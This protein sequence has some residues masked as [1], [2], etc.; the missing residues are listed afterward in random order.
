MKVLM[1][2]A[3]ILQALNYDDNL[4]RPRGRPGE[5]MYGRR[6]NTTDNNS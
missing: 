3:L 4:L 2:L 5:T 6:K 1:V